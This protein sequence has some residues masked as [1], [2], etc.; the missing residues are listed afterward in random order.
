MRREFAFGPDWKWWWRENTQ[1]LTYDASTDTVRA[2]TTEGRR[3]KNT[4]E[5]FAHI[6]ELARRHDRESG[7]PPYT[8]ADGKGNV[9]TLRFHLSGV[10]ASR[11]V[12]PRGGLVLEGLELEDDCYWGAL[13]YDWNFAVS[14]KEAT[15]EFRRLFRAEKARRGP[16]R[17]AFGHYGVR[18]RPPSWRWVELLDE[19]AFIPKPRHD[20]NDRSKLRQGCIWAERSLKL[21]I[22]VFDPG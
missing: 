5:P 8:T 18:S 9:R 20:P 15:E 22:Q 19:K 14:V 21:I 2:K 12:R 7:F 16:P 6:Y 1:D 13:D 17:E 4:V 11:V 3:W 10:D